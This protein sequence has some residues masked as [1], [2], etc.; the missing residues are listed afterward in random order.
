M[1]KV[2]NN[3]QIIRKFTARDGNSME[4]EKNMKNKKAARPMTTKE[5][6]YTIC[7][8][9]REKGKMPEDILDYSLPYTG[10]EPM[11]TY[12]FELG[13][14]LGYGGN[15][16]IY[17]DFWM[18]YDRVGQKRISPIG[19]FKTLRK[20]EEAMHLMAGLLASFIVEGCS[21]VNSHLDDFTW[22][23]ADVH[24]VLE[25]GTAAGWGY[26]C[27]SMERALKRKD[28]LLE[29]YPCVVVRDNA[30]RKETIYKAGGH[31]LMGQGMQCGS[32]LR[33]D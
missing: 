9:M 20:D 32:L 6:F 14:H 22:E 19:T 18:E 3:K 31:P 5:Y 29:S 25:D 27:S 13:N 4:K 12:E 16:G 24:A 21:Y 7:G 1:V 11:T 10:P 33:A 26:S 28:K 17:L 2:S 8:I 15:E 23:G 30:T